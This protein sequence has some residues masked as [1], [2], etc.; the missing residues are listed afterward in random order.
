MFHPK[1]LD[2]KISNSPTLCELRLKREKLQDFEAESSWTLLQR[3]KKVVLVGE[4]MSNGL[5]INERGNW[6]I[7]CKKKE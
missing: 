4:I 6:I 7:R 2:F 3:P 5:R 1:N